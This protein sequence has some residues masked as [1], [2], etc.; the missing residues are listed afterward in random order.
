MRLAAPYYAE[1][2]RDK[3]RGFPADF[4]LILCSTFVD[5]ATLR[6]L[7]PDGFRTIPILTYFHENQFAYPMQVYDERDFHYPLTNFTTAMASDRL[8]FNSAYNLES[9]LEGCR[10][11]F[12]KVPDMK[13][14]DYEEIIRAKA[15]ILHPALDFSQADSGRVARR[16]GARVIVWNHRWE[17]DKNPEFFF[18]ALYQLQEQGRDFRLIVLGQ[19]F[20]EQPAIFAEARK[21]LADKIVHFGY[22]ADR[23]EYFRLLHQ[24]D[25]V[26]STAVHEF[27]GIAVIEAVRCGCRP[28]LPN[29]L[30]YPELFGEEFLYEEENFMTTLTDLLQQPRRNENEESILTDRFSW[31]SLLPCYRQW[32]EARL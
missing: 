19:S 24:G 20:H 31:P 23:A 1:M 18:N 2:L 3:H 30:S 5:V 7:L 14:S 4:D 21:K 22:A 11:F 17:H 15:V 13:I 27:Y 8:A 32:F 29:R 9:F 16:E 26:V 25:I 10:L 28:L 12:K 6:S